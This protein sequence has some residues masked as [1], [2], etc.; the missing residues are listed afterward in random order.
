MQ[1]FH[2][3][4]RTERGAVHSSRKEA[5]EPSCRPVALNEH[6]W[7]GSRWP[8]KN[9]AAKTLISSFLIRHTHLLGSISECD[10][11]VS[12]LRLQTV[13]LFLKTETLHC[14][15]HA[16]LDASPVIFNQFCVL[17]TPDEVPQ[18]EGRTGFGLFPRLWSFSGLFLQS[19]WT[20]TLTRFTSG[21]ANELQC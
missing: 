11:S 10:I 18:R 20:F 5:D 9:T 6:C 17:F 7:D 12:C 4:R 1:Y 15:A 8:F 14:R 13:S 3:G 2:V 16:S 19:F 21:K